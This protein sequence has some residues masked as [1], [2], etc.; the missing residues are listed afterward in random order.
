MNYTAIDRQ[1]N[2]FDNNS[3]RILSEFKTTRLQCDS[4]Q[5]SKKEKNESLSY[6]SLKKE[7]N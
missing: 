2:I 7:M 3:F 4:F 6:K 1:T 5:Q